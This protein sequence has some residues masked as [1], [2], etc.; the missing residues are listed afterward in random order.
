MQTLV[1]IIKA[2]CEIAIIFTVFMLARIVW[3]SLNLNF[4]LRWRPA[5]KGI[6]IYYKDNVYFAEG[7]R[8]FTHEYIIATVWKQD[9]NGKWQY[10]YRHHQT[11]YDHELLSYAH[12]MFHEAVRAYVNRVEDEAMAKRAQEKEMERIAIERAMKEKQAK[13]RAAL[14]HLLANPTR[15]K[16]Q[17]KDRKD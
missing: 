13:E 6:V 4:V 1:S 3:H 17:I 8:D 9:E 10:V 14:E 11:F 16:M 7:Q 12:Q 2:I 5:I 15:I